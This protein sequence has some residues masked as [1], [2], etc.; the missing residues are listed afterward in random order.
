MDSFLLFQVFSRFGGCAQIRIKLPFKRV[1]NLHF[2]PGSNEVLV[3]EHDN[4]ALWRFEW[5]HAGAPQFCELA[6][7]IQIKKPP[8]TPDVL[9][10]KPSSLSADPAA[11][12]NGAGETPKDKSNE[13]VI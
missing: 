9:G 3:T 2:R 1:S 7:D 10:V 13:T 12:S 6:G 11:S 4:H 8:P 5:K